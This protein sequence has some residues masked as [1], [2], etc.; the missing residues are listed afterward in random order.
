M[1][2]QAPQ[3]YIKEI[4][5]AQTLKDFF[6]QHSCAATQDFDTFFQTIIDNLIASQI[7]VEKRC[8]FKRRTDIP[9]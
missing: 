9:C 3:P 2:L 6:N 4:E 7:F 5:A 8:F 1:P